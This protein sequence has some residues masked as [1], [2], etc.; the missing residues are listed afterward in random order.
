VPTRV[1]DFV[2]EYKWLQTN[3][4][5]RTGELLADLGFGHSTGED[6]LLEAQ[7]IQ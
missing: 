2:G 4:L 7:L 3:D 1:R 6:D 5:Q